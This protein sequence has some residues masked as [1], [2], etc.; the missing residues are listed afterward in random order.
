VSENGSPPSQVVA[1]FQELPELAR[2]AVD[3]FLP[4]RSKV[5]IVNALFKDSGAT[6]ITK[7]LF[8]KQEQH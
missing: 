7:R 2:V 3:P 4:I 1:A 6:E 5:N 8:G